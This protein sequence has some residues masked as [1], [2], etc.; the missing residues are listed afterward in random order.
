MFLPPNNDHNLLCYNEMIE[1]SSARC[2]TPMFSPNEEN[3]PGLE[4]IDSQFMSLLTSQF[5]LLFE[6]QLDLLS[7]A[8]LLSELVDRIDAVD[9]SCFQM[10]PAARVFA[11]HTKAGIH[12]R[13][14]EFEIIQTILM[15]WIQE[16][17]SFD[18]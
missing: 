13:Q 9:L 6:E 7:K 1:D 10:A 11:A 4:I 12:G 5:S 14:Y 3:Q 15:K 2:S 8:A 18:I 16:L 17:E